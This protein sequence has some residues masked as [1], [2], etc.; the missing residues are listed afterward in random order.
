MRGSAVPTPTVA[1]VR[2]VRVMSA[3]T[4]RLL[5]EGCDRLLEIGKGRAQA[6]ALLGRKLREQLGYAPGHEVMDALELAASPGGQLDDDHTPIARI[7]HAPAE[8]LLDER[9][10]ELRERRRGQ[11]AALR[12]LAAAERAIAELPQHANALERQSTALV[13]GL[14]HQLAEAG[15]DGQEKA[16]ELGVALGVRTVIQAGGHRS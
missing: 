9:I 10:D 3:G 16:G 2:A 6:R 15:K 1:S 5:T 13:R 14:R 8:P 12:Q 7:L 4:R 11:R